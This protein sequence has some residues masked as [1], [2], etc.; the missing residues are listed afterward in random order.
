VLNN[1][2]L[3]EYIKAI[4]ETYEIVDPMEKYKG[5]VNLSSSHIGQPQ[6]ELNYSKTN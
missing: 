1:E 6:F 4:Y 3:I 5:G 2:A